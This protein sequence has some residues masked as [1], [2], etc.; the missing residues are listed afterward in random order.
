MCYAKFWALVELRLEKVY[1]SFPSLTVV[2]LFYLA[3][4]FTVCLVALGLGSFGHIAKC[5]CQF[6]LTFYDV[7]IGKPKLTNSCHWL[8]QFIL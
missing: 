8:I 6:I 4:G 3:E 2:L 5:T 7:M 1:Q